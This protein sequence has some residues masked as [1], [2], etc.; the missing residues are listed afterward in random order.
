MF[1]YDQHCFVCSYF[2]NA[3]ITITTNT[4]DSRH[5]HVQNQKKKTKQSMINHFF[6]VILFSK[7][8]LR[9]NSSH[10][11]IAIKYSVTVLRTV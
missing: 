2:P 7:D 8:Q 1:F 10:T 9:G 6:L 11:R 4:S 5:G 3:T